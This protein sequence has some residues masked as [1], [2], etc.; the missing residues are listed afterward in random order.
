MHQ[1]HGRGKGFTLLELM[2][3]ITLVATIMV[4][5]YMVLH[6]T[7]A[8]SSSVQEV[9][10]RSEIGPAILNIIRRDLEGAFLPDDKKEYFVGQDKILSANADRIDFVTMAL[11]YDRLTDDPQEKP[12][13]IPI[14]ES[15][16]QLRLN[17]QNAS[18]MVLYRREDPF[19]DEEPLKGGKLVELYDRITNFN[20]QYYDG[21]QWV[22]E[23]NN[24]KQNKGLP[25]AVKI[26][27][28]LEPMPSED[29]SELPQPQSFVVTVCLMR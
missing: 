14:V 29:L 5:L 6:S 8:V 24:L 25:H 9:I 7:L 21:Q 13:W 16:Y 4:V 2:L 19:I 1:S 11:S 17:Q 18:Y 27:L 10:A 15:G 28:G 23:W 22:D 3:A 26:E 20:L 12:R